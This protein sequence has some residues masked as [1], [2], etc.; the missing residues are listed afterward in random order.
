MKL[1]LFVIWLCSLAVVIALSVV[2]DVMVIENNEDK[3]LHVTIFCLLTLWPVMALK[4]HLHIGAAAAFLLLMGG[5]M[6]LLQALAP[7]RQSSFADMVANVAGIMVGLLIGY[8]LR[9]GAAR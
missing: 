4:R 3:M 8:L 6:E 7:E 1:F 2:P 5:A 9:S